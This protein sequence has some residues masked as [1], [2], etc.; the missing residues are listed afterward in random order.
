MKRTRHPSAEV[1]V[2]PQGLLSDQ[3]DVEEDF[4]GFPTQAAAMEMPS[5]HKISYTAHPGT[6]APKLFDEG[7]GEEEFEGFTKYEVYVVL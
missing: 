7:P 5:E 2:V 6:V 3:S 1:A 4:W